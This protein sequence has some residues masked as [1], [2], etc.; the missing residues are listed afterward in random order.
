MPLCDTVS[1]GCGYGGKWRERHMMTFLGRAKSFLRDD[2]GACAAEYAVL[3]SLIVVA[4][5]GPISAL[6]EHVAGI[7]E[8]VGEI[9]SNIRLSM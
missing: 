1:P 6:G 5:I 3:L 2:G 4:T 9:L 7:F 8:D